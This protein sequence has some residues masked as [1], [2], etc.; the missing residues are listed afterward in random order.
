MRG[1]ASVIS[2]SEQL[3]VRFPEFRRLFRGCL[4]KT[5]HASEFD[6]DQSRLR[7][8]AVSGLAIRTYR[9]AH[10]DGWHLT[11]AD[12]SVDE[13]AGM[14]AQLASLQAQ[15]PKLRQEL[16][17]VNAAANDRRRRF[18]AK[19]VVAE[20]PSE[21]TAAWEYWLAE[22][23]AQTTIGMEAHEIA[24]NLVRLQAE[25][26]WLER[27]LTRG[28]E[29]GQPSLAGLRQMF[30]HVH[31]ERGDEMLEEMQCLE[32]QMWQQFEQIFMR[33]RALVQQR[34]VL[35]NYNWRCAG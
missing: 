3:A 5:R 31:A 7:R 16:R 24:G 27:V 9:C 1:E 8:E 11:S 19:K 32:R 6:A 18:F 29:P 34:Y 2:L 4:R 30:A 13:K 25:I 12:Y 28:L 22:H 21:V 26:R 14:Q 23:Q 20:F 10:C 15:L 35:P 33:A 17:R